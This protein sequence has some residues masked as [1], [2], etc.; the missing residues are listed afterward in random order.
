M[1]SVYGT[2]AFPNS[3]LFAVRTAEWFGARR[4]VLPRKVEICRG[5]CRSYFGS[6]WDDSIGVVPHQDG[7]MVE[8]N[9]LMH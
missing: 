9:S 2:C 6:V 5:E 8:W 4:L 3:H 1:F 7:K